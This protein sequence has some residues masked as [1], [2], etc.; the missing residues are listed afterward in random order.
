MARV[1]ASV[2]E[3]P[4]DLDFHEAISLSFY[5]SAANAHTRLR[6]LDDGVKADVEV[7]QNVASGG[8]WTTGIA[9]DICKC[10]Y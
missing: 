1:N 3:R 4:I 10:P 5:G 2:L 9:F 6:K 8:G 7:T